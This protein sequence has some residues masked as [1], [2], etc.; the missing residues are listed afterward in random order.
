MKR[1]LLS[2]LLVLCICLPSYAHRM[3]AGTTDQYIY[4]VAVDSTDLKTRETGFSSFT[5]YYSINGGAAAA[6]ASVTVN[7]TD[8]SNMPGVYEYLVDTGAMRII[9][10]ISIKKGDRNRVS[11]IIVSPKKYLAA[12]PILESLDPKIEFQYPIKGDKFDFI[13]KRVEI[14]NVWANT[15]ASKPPKSRFRLQLIVLPE[16]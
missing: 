9:N 10:D 4:F 12:A 1:L 13:Y 8:S 2:L 16:N 11:E 15:Y 5:V 6:D 14:A 3:A 7:E